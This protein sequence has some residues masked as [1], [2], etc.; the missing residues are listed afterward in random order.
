M[1]SSVEERGEQQV[2]KIFVR[3]TGPPPEDPVCDSGIYC[4]GKKNIFE[5][6]D[7]LVWASPFRERAG[8]HIF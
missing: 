6:F 7:F 3:E 4:Y 8:H 1:A 5:I 2:K